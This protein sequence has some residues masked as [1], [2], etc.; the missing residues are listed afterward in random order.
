VLSENL[1][2]NLTT[3]SIEADLNMSSIKTKLHIA[4]IDEN[5]FLRQAWQ[6]YLNQIPDF[7]VQVAVSGIGTAVQT[8][9]FAQVNLS[10]IHLGAYPDFVLS[11]LHNHR[12]Y[13]Q[14]QTIL[15]CQNGDEHPALLKAV[16]A[17]AV[18][19]FNRLRPLEDLTEFLLQTVQGYS[20]M[21]PYLAAKII[22]HFG[23][24]R[25]K[26]LFS[27]AGQQ[28]LAGLAAGDTVQVMAEKTGLAGSRISAKVQE[29]YRIIRENSAGI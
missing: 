24:V 11:D 29:M 20:A 6:L 2:S 23:T 27:A 22:K 18:N 3:V 12:S 10:L 17:G 25:G 16:A 14:N 4:L 8:P 28:I 26:I 21:S 13:F 19:F 15:I 1:L 9:G 7:A 5:S